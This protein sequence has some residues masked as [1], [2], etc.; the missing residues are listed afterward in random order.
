MWKWSLPNLFIPAFNPG[1][2]RKS[3]K[4][5]VTLI[6]VVIEIRTEY[7]SDR[8]QKCYRFS[9]LPRWKRNPLPF[10]FRAEEWWQLVSLK[11]F[12]RSTQPE[13]SDGPN[14]SCCRCENHKSHACKLEIGD[15]P[16]ERI[17]DLAYSL[18]LE[19]IC[20]TICFFSR[21]SI[22]EWVVWNAVWNMS[23]V[24]G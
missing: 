9:Q 24:I 2:W 14:L 5:S 6:G 22:L 7:L 12:Y 4:T 1:Y 16:G 23:Y 21:F 18:R 11:Y 17:A 8:N 13:T 15:L 20:L 3:R 10:M 19:L